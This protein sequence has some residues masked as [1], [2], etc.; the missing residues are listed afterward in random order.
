MG[1]TT[2]NRLREAGFTVDVIEIGDLAD[3]D[4]AR[5]VG[6]TSYSGEVHLCTQ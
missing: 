4:T 2:S 6:L 3:A 1:P 5:R